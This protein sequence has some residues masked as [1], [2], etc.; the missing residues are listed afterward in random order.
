MIQAPKGGFK[1]E[2]GA[3][4]VAPLAIHKMQKGEMLP[5]ISKAAIEKLK[6]L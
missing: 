6:V 4:N 3:K 5:T 1:T 2:A